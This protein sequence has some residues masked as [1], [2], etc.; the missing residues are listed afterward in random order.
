MRFTHHSHQ[1]PEVMA[2]VFGRQ[3]LEL[4]SDL[5]TEKGGWIINMFNKYPP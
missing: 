1:S 3:L 5:D 4:G 2:V